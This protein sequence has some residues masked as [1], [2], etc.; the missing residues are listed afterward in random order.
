MT[1]HVPKDLLNVHLRTLGVEHRGGRAETA[2]ALDSVEA[3]TYE[4]MEELV[5]QEEQTDRQKDRQTGEVGKTGRDGRDGPK[6]AV[7]FFQEV[8]FRAIEKEGKSRPVRR[9]KARKAPGEPNGLDRRN[10][11]ES[12]SG[13]PSAGPSAAASER[14]SGQASW[15]STEQACKRRQF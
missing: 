6:K 1:K 4:W 3:L 7:R 10:E 13:A 11:L 12:K 8:H 5:C 14:R 15:P 9:L 2:P